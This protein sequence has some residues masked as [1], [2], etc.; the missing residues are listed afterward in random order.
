VQTGR[1]ERKVRGISSS[2]FSLGS[3]PN[4]L[5]LLRRCGMEEK[6]KEVSGKAVASL[7]CVFFSL[8]LSPLC[9]ARIA[10]TIGGLKDIKAG[11]ARGW[12]L[13]I[14]GLFVNLSV[15]VV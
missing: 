1:V 13:A 12:G 5:A 6:R 4:R 11:K 15:F 2:L 10:L 9:L 14:V 7:F 3:I 8:L